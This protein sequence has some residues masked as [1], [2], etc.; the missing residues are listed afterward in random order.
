MANQVR[1]Q[2]L[3]FIKSNK[4]YVLSGDNEIDYYLDH[5]YF[6]NYQDQPTFMEENLECI[7]EIL[8]NL[9]DKR[10]KK[11]YELRYFYDNKNL[12]WSEVAGVLGMSIQTAINLHQHGRTILRKKILYKKK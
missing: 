4:K 5:Q 11:V 12:S 2:C 6:L 9:N 7:F 8:D 1:Y 10:I 3:N